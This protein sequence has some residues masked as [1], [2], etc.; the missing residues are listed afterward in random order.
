[1]AMYLLSAD[2][3]Y[4]GEEHI[5][6]KMGF[7]RRY[8]QGFERGFEKFRDGYRRA[9]G[10][11]LHSPKLFAASFLAFCVFV[12]FARRRSR[13]RFLSEGRRRADSPAHARSH[14]SAH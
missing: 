3:E 1:M 7:F 13:P 5:G 2:D 8:Q 10:I 12:R 6:E 14:R 9:L 11:A 4:H